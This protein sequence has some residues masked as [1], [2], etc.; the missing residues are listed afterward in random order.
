MNE[1]LRLD[2]AGRRHVAD[3]LERKLA[4]AGQDDARADGKPSRASASA[5]AAV[6][7]GQLR[8]GVQFQ[9]REMLA[10]HV[11]NAEILKNDRVDADFGQGGDGLDQFRQ[12]ILT[13]QSVYGDED[14][15]RRREAVEA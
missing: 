4:K 5:P 1:H 11:I 3:F 13:N 9:L 15:A 6:V 7:D 2:A 8:A 14:A 12:F 10:E